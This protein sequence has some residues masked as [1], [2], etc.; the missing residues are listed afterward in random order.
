MCARVQEVTGGSVEVGY[1]DQVSTG[2]GPAAA[3]AA[4]RIRP[5]IVKLAEGKKGFVLLPKRRV[6][7]RS[8]SWAARFRRLARDDERLAASLENLPWLAFV[9][10]MLASFFRCYGSVQALIKEAGNGE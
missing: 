4:S 10:L 1:A 2:P 9:S 5:E 6:V 7:E 8:F 3:A